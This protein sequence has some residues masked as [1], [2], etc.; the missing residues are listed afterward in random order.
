LEDN[1][2]C[3]LSVEIKKELPIQNFISS[4]NQL[5]KQRKIH[6]KNIHAK[7]FKTNRLAL[8][9]PPSRIFKQKENNPT[10]NDGNV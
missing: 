5:Q 7:T 10:R 1:E 9:L 8:K 3:I 4:E 6:F 2:Q